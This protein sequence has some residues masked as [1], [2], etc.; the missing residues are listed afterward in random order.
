MLQQEK[1]SAHVVEMVRNNG[2]SDKINNG[3]D[4][5]FMFD[6][7]DVMYHKKLLDVEKR[8]ENYLCIKDYFEDYRKYKV[9][10]KVLSLYCEQDKTQGNPFHV[11]RNAVELSNAPFIGLIQITLCKENYK[12]W[13]EAKDIPSFLK[14][15]E[16]YILNAAQK[17]WK[18][19][20]YVIEA[21]QLYRSSTTGD[22]C[23]VMRTGSVEAIYQTASELGNVRGG[24][25]DAGSGRVKLFTYTNVGIECSMNQKGEFCTLNE[26]FVQK[27]SDYVVAL[28]F[29]AAVQFGEHLK[30]YVQQR[31]DTG[32]RVEKVK[33]LFGRYDFL[34]N[35]SMEE[36]AE[37]YPTL[38]K[39]KLGTIQE[40]EGESAEIEMKSADTGSAASLKLSDIIENGFAQNINER[41][42]VNFSVRAAKE[43]TNQQTEDE[44]QRVISKNNDIYEDVEKLKDWKKYYA[45]E[46]GEF[47]ELLR[48]MKEM[49]RT[50]LPAGME[51]DAY[52][53]WL[54]FRQDMAVLCKCINNKM[55]FYEKIAE[56]GCDEEELK[57]Y[58]VGVLLNWRANIQAINQYTRLVQNVNYQTYQSPVYEIQ[59]QIDTEKAMVAYREVMENY[60]Y[61]YH[62]G[63]GHESD[64]RD[65]IRA[66]IYPEMA[67]SGVEVGAPFALRMKGEMINR[68]IFCTVPSFEYFGRLYDLLPW[69]I[70]EC[71]HQ[72]RVLGRE[73]RNNFIVGSVLKEVFTSVVLHAFSNA[74]DDNLYGQIG[75]VERRLS[76]AMAQIAKEDIF[77]GTDAGKM[78]GFLG[79]ATGNVK[80]SGFEEIVFR[81]Q[82]YL[83]RLF[84]TGYAFLEEKEDNWESHNDI[85][86]KVTE[87]LLEAGRDQG[88]KDKSYMDWME[89]I[90]KKENAL[91]KVQEAVVILLDSYGKQMQESLRKMPGVGKRFALCK[92]EVISMEDLQVHIGELDRR[93]IRKMD[94][95]E[96]RL[97]KSN[98]DVLDEAWEVLRH[99]CF[100]IKKMYRVYR[101]YKGI[102]KKPEDNGYIDSFLSKVFRYYQKKETG[103]TRRE[104]DL[105]AD[106]PT[107]RA[108]RNLGLLNGDDE[109]FHN[110]MKHY[111]RDKSMSEIQGLAEFRVKQYR[112]TVADILMA[113]SLQMGSFGYCRQVFQTISDTKIEKKKELHD[114]VNMERFRLVTAVLLE[115]EN[116][117]KRESQWDG[118]GEICI[119]G[120]SLIEQ[121]KIYCEYTFRSIRDTLLRRTDL[122]EDEK[123]LIGELLETMNVQTANY[124]EKMTKESYACTLLHF[125]LHKWSI[126]GQKEIVEIWKNRYSRI[127]VYLSQSHY[128][129]FRLEYLCVGLQLILTKNCVVVSKERF[130]YI[131]HIWKEAKSALSK[132]CRWE[133][134]MADCL[135]EPKRNVG[136]FYNDPTQVYTL[137]EG[138]KLDNTIDFIQNYYYNNRFRVMDAEEEEAK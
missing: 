18:E 113:L 92:E 59:T 88:L 131:S 99:Y 48:C 69:L 58:R 14:R 49:C 45:E 64:K 38:C 135:A 84:E 93:L 11:N 36:F 27:H 120:G 13:K 73:E 105:C 130:E 83:S 31:D 62:R 126:K 119:E 138:G 87:E 112:E 2:I 4:C 103:E 134:K 91:G 80:E 5:F 121:S 94:Q 110:K 61:L 109:L 7:F 3:S 78:D 51:Q 115:S 136:R 60:L 127:E 108:M 24:T 122:E 23:L 42:L 97:S 10:Y 132:G 124:L 28:R 15:C 100:S 12:N 81:T 85:R 26:E 86:A 20:G 66:L 54:T 53:N 68:E 104:F 32:N 96:K 82:K 71:S 111:M 16:K 114:S 29:S 19:S 57:K 79:S 137:N 101:K 17:L 70:H 8:Y 1:Y 46:H 9:S 63:V 90:G 55:R 35:I 47:K 129:F 98:P 40:K 89:E 95:I 33:G 21:S 75:Q 56:E 25:S 65:C 37:I 30:K 22:F 34:L 44:W 133:E 50:F 6:Y 43:Q 41:I 123:Q 74:S 125:M 72:I 76:Y 117:E 116:A 118:E 128:R 52:I 39:K 67:R 77:S 107:H 102:I 106:L